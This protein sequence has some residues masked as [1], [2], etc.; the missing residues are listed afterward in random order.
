MQS[1]RENAHWGGRDCVNAKNGGVLYLGE[2]QNADIRLYRAGDSQILEVIDNTES[3][4]S[5][6]VKTEASSSKSTQETPTSTLEIQPSTGSPSSNKSTQSKT[7]LGVYKTLTYQHS[8]H[9]PGT[10]LSI[11]GTARVHRYNVN[12]HWRSSPPLQTNSLPP[13]RIH[14]NR[15]SPMGVVGIGR[16]EEKGIICP[17]HEL[18]DRDQLLKEL[19]IIVVSILA[20]QLTISVDDGGSILS[21]PDFFLFH[22]VFYLFSPPDR[23]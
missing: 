16:R 20:C 6:R 15:Q 14:Q 10:T 4:T 9:P 23:G 19:S 2:A 12:S 8:R 3:P 7:Y 22:F 1:Q 18:W 13:A 21:Q 5:S 17:R 11:Y